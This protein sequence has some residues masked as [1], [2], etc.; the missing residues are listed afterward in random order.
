MDLKVVVDGMRFVGTP[1][2]LGMTTSATAG[3]NDSKTVGRRAAMTACLP[4]DNIPDTLSET[5]PDSSDAAP[6]AVHIYPSGISGNEQTLDSPT[7]MVPEESMPTEVTV[8]DD[9]QVEAEYT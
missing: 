4:P 3:P 6:G 5:I 9:A 7:S 8:L 2:I 1:S